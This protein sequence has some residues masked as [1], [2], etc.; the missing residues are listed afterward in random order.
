MVGGKLPRGAALLSKSDS[1]ELSRNLEELLTAQN[2]RGMKMARGHLREGYLLR[3]A[4]TIQR[5]R[6]NVF[7]ITGFPVLGT[8]E[9]D[10]PAGAMALYQLCKR[11]GLTP[12]ILSDGTITS[13]LSS[14]FNCLALHSGSSTEVYES[15]RALYESSPPDLV[16]SIERP[17]LTQDGGYYNISG[18]N[19]SNKCSFAE[20]YL[21]VAQCPNIAIGDGGNEI[22]MGNLADQLLA[23]PVRTSISCC[24]EL[25]VADVSNWA[26]YALC[27][28]VDSLQGR[29]PATDLD[30]DDLLDKLILK[31]AVD[32][33]TGKATPT[34]DGF[35]EGTGKNMLEKI[36]A[37]VLD[38]HRL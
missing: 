24:D 3:A 19:I 26:A 29:S 33:V 17:G 7:I 21:E 1:K 25:I 14:D 15:A 36:R 4:D 10:G 32:G 37:L 22:G 35:P 31:G 18:T 23:L 27:A 13:A 12:W 28:L 30:V 34:E 38:Y 20:P 11:Q 5:T 9:T 6:G 2:H 8:F 16:I